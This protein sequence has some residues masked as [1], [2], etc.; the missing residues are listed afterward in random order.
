M[1][2]QEVKPDTRRAVDE[3]SRDSREEREVAPPAK[4]SPAAEN[5]QSDDTPDDIALDTTLQEPGEAGDNRRRPPDR[6]Q[7]RNAG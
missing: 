3:R 2:R 6:G 5:P 1:T 4:D 7:I